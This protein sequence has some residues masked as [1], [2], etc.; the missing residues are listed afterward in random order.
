M[1]SSKPEDGFD[2]L[3]HNLTQHE[4]ERG[5]APG[6]VEGTTFGAGRYELQG[7]LGEGATAIVYRAWDRQLNRPVALKVLRESGALS[8]IAR[9]RFRREAETAAN[10]TH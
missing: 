2:A 5:A 8:P 7:M 10:L 9:E 3:F 6:P 1:P 4:R